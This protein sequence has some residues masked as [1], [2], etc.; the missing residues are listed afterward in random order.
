[1]S[2]HATVRILRLSLENVTSYQN[3]GNSMP[4]KSFSH[5]PYEPYVILLCV[6]LKNRF[7]AESTKLM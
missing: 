1:M 6:T 7:K 2:C 5:F 4:L 3:F